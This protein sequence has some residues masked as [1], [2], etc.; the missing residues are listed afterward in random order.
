MGSLKAFCEG[1]R[2]ELVS[3]GTACVVGCE[4]SERLEIPDFVLFGPAR[5]RVTKI[6]GLRG[7]EVQSIRI[8]AYVEILGGMCFHE[9]SSLKEVIFA[10]DSHLREIR[11]GTFC[12]SG[13]VRIE[14][15]SSV[16]ILGEN[17]FWKC[18]SLKEVIFPADSHLRE[19]R[20]GAFWRSGIERIELPSSVEILGE[21]CF[22][23]CRSLKEVDRKSVV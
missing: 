6:R 8:G 9:C 17:C 3:E 16:E 14:L 5:F 12:E 23:G 19:I 15:P 20:E 13:I 7:I 4:P 22:C 1:V 21:M 2:Y 10:A 11:G 18:S